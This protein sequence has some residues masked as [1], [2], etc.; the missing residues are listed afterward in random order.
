MHDPRPKLCTA[1]TIPCPYLLA[2]CLQLGGFE[3]A[4][5]GLAA[6]RYTADQFQVLT[7]Y[8]GWGPGQLEDE[9]RRGVWLPVAACAGAVLQQ[10]ELPQQQRVAGWEQPTAAAAE[11]EGGAAAAGRCSMWHAIAQ[12]AG[13]DLALLSREVRGVADPLIAAAAASAGASQRDLQQQQEQEQGQQA[14]ASAS[15]EAEAEPG[16][17]DEQPQVTEQGDQQ[18]RGPG[19]ASG[20]WHDG[21]GI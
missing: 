3:A 20:G 11:G 21:A 19:R 6:G 10:L 16:R 8:A 12:L 17:G 13:G 2:V 18:S 4:K 14:T 9:C 7:R 15:P 1:P 5:A